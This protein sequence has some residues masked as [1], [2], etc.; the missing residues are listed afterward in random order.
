MN[1]LREIG[2]LIL[3]GSIGLIT[4]LSLDLS[5]IIAIPLGMVCAF[6]ACTLNDYIS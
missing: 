6:L 3:F 2:C 4:V 1:A 5:V